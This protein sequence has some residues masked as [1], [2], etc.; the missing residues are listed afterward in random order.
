[1]KRFSL[2][3]IASLAAAG[4]ARADVIPACAVPT[5]ATLIGF[6]QLP[7]AVRKAL[8]K[9]TGPMAQPGQPFNASDVID[10][11]K[12]LPQWRGIF[13]WSRGTRWVVA[14]E[15]GGRGYS[16]PVFLFD[17]TANGKR[18]ALTTSKTANPTTVCA[19]AQDLLSTQ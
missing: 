6:D 17:A 12:P 5:G 4:A 13:V 11:K 8:A 15:H 16:D 1:M 3:I 10:D 7:M 18:V 14:T 19:M 2:V 9:Q